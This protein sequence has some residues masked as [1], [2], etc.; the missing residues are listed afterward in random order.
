MTQGAHE[1]MVWTLVANTVLMVKPAGALDGLIDRAAEAGA[2]TMDT[3]GEATD[4][5]AE[6]M[7]T[8]AFE[9]G[10]VVARYVRAAS[11]ESSISVM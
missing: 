7:D 11:Q 4:V 1:V 8:A 5:G 10:L 9:A 2:E 3:A 6:T